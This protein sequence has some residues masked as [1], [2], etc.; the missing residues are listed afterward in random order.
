MNQ[1]FLLS[2]S[3]HGL[4][5]ASPHRQ[6]SGGW[7]WGKTWKEQIFFGRDGKTIRIKTKQVTEKAN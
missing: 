6:Q 1:A 5:M 4:G 3:V 2:F 7:G